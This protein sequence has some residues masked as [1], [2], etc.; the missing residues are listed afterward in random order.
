MHPKL[1]ALDVAILPPPEVRD[2]AIALSAAIESSHEDRL[3]L[4]ADH[5]PHVTLTQQFIR[6]E[7][8]D[9]A[10]ERVDEVL[11]GESSLRLRV[12]GTGKGGH[13]VWITIERDEAIAALHERLMEALRGFERSGGT[14]AAFYDGDARV[15]DVVWVAGYRLKSSFGAFTPHI[16]LGQGGT[17]PPIEPFTFEATTV[18]AC[19]LGRFCSCRRALRTWTLI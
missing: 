3:L 9:A 11:R 17:P 16:T 18:A 4:D 15:G 2:R 10:F 1:L 14:P 13:S 5:L 12:S 19:H 8:L 6:E 7:E